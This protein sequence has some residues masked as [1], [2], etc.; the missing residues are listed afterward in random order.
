MPTA[1]HHPLNNMGGF[2]LFIKS[3]VIMF[4]SMP[5]LYFCF[6]CRSST[7]PLVP[8]TGQPLLLLSSETLSWGSRKTPLLAATG[9]L[10]ACPPKASPVAGGEM[11]ISA[12]EEEI[13]PGGWL[14]EHNKPL[15][16]LEEQVRPLCYSLHTS[17]S[18][19]LPTAGGMGSKTPHST[20]TFCFHAHA[21]QGS[22]SC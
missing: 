20:F 7:R 3:I 5:A 12:A 22:T 14:L 19:T 8:G 10:A 1:A 15:L 16:L 21:P 11:L 17:W 13:T 6:S 9:A 18:S 4:S 2:F